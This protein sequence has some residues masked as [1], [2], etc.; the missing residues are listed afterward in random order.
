MN[1][2]F[3][4]L[5]AIGILIAAA[6]AFFKFG[7]FGAAALW[8]MSRGGTWLLP[9]VVV[10]SLVDSINPCAF[11]I[12]LL[13]IAF[14]FSIGHLR[15]GILKI[16]SSYIAGIFI[17]YILIGLGILQTLH[18]FS[19]PHFMAK[20][21]ALLLVALGLVNVANEFFPAFPIK[22]RIPHAAHHKMAE[23]MEKG[24]MPTAF[25]LGGLVGLC[26]F[27]CTGGPYL[28]VLGLLHDQAT[29]L[30]GMGYLLLY[31]AIFIL[32]LALILL[33]AS[34]RV[35]LD[36]VRVWQARDRRLM[37]LGGGV[38]MIALGAF[39]FWL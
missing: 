9:L 18:L 12:L 34:D 36:R 8:N 4:M 38:A 39:I 6:V 37:R 28:M 20:V 27:P 33:I 5:V 2:R 23:L 25:L 11:S 31:N 19:V 26:E 16:G 17:V 22:F 29:Y 35:L 24:S 30:W 14:L 21:G 7:N 1:K 10:S 3:I 15:S 32:P 13:T